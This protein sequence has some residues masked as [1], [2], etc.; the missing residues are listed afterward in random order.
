M[1]FRVSAPASSANLGP[2]FDSL[3]LALDLWLHVDVERCSGETIHD[4]GAQ[5]LYG[6]E[7]LV[8]TAMRFAAEQRG[9]ALP[10]CGIRVTSG[11]PV[12]RGLGSSAAAI[13][14]GIRVAAVL[15][16]QVNLD[17]RE[18]VAIGGAME[19]HA[20][21]VSASALGGVTVAIAT[22]EGYLAE[23]LASHLP[24]IPVLFIP[25]AVALTKE[26]RGILPDRVPLVDAAANVG[27][28]ALLA[29]ALQTGRDELLREAMRDTLHQPY[30][31]AIFPH[32]QPAIA[33][34]TAAGAFGASLSGAGPTV[35]ALASPAD[36]H[37]VG[38]AMASA[39]AEVGVAGQVMEL[40]IP[41]SGC[42]VR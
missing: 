2:G 39:S 21:N 22:E 11:I 32:L 6:G 31:T 28:S 12:A 29:L 30:R 23:V 8:V 18:I 42:V 14:A 40:A 19:G 4:L 13:V 33:A 1:S 3:A 5:E 35:L 7:N 38:E 27:R 25:D 41:A 26:A 34:A 20:D 36:A 17:D 9:W 37:V 15:A 10:G 16:G 24:W